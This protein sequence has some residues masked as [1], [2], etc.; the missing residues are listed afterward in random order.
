[1]KTEFK[2]RSTAKAAQDGYRTEAGWRS[3]G[4][5]LLK[6]AKPVGETSGKYRTIFYPI[7]GQDQT[8]A[9]KPRTEKQIAASRKAIRKKS[10]ELL[11][12]AENVQIDVLCIPWDLLTQK[13]GSDLRSYRG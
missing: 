3:V 13:A 11:K 9:V 12:W 1:M 6:D 2:Y 5:V 7:Y 4:R 8:R 10:E